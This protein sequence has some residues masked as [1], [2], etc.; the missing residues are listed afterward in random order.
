MPGSQ[1]EGI[2]AGAAAGIMGWQVPG[3]ALIDSSAPATRNTEDSMG[4]H[5]PSTNPALDE[6]PQGGEKEGGCN[7]ESD[8]PAVGQS[9]P[10]VKAPAL[11]GWNLA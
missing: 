1:L 10:P 4:C 11:Q 7:G 2:A 9:S 8:R 6:E 3:V 5:C